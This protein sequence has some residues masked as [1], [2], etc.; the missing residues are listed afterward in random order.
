MQ[1]RNFLASLGAFAS[2]G[3]E[4]V[5]RAL[6]ED[7]PA[8]NDAPEQN[9][10]YRVIDTHVHLFN[11]RRMG[12]G[13]IPVLKYLSVDATIEGYVAAMRQGNVDKG[14][15]ITYNAED[16]APQLRNYKIDPAAVRLVYNTTY[17]LTAL[18]QHPELFWWFPEHIDPV[19][20]TYLED[21]EKNFERGAAGIKMMSV[22]HGY[23]PDHPAYIPVYEMC[24]K[25]KKPI[26]MDLSFWYLSTMPAMNELE[27]RRNRVHRFSDYAELLAPI[28]KQFSDIPISLAH[29]GTA[30]RVSD[31][32]E[33]F[34]FIAQFPNLSCDVAAATGY[35]AE[36]LEKLVK[37]VGAGKIM[38]GTD[39]PY[40][41]SG[42]N[43]YLKGERR[44]TMIA[45]ECPALGEEQKRAILAGN[46]ERF[47]A[48]QMPATIGSDGKESKRGS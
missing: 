24:R 21:L 14:F 30:L 38:Y 11:S 26:I 19:R 42:V 28:F 12:S 48:Y 34:P 3:S 9:K 44:W 29:T 15:L 40:W 13:G 25:Y 22:F 20:E 41:A 4:M 39:W 27:E 5:T 45:D 1:R 43:S 2:A 18:E 31:Y 35:S 6:A 23:F 10:R 32:D 46:A 37:A 7:N 47:V 8:K 17:Q 36:W 33:I 16:V